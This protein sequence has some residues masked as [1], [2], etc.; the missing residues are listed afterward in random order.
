ML[1]LSAFFSG[2]ET[3]ITGL[4]NFK[5]RALIKEQGETRRIFM[6]MMKTS[7]AQ[8]EI[9]S[10]NKASRLILLDALVKYFEE[11]LEGMGRI[12]SIAVLKEIFG[13]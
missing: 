13:D 2:S 9:I 1:L 7:L 4:D 5:L 3:A 12:K 8:A 10:L 6:E 11:H